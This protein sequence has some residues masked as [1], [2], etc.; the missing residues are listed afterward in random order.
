MPSL[1]LI[2]IYLLLVY[3]FFNILYRAMV[4]LEKQAKIQELNMLGDFLRQHSPFEDEEVE[5]C[6]RETPYARDLDGGDFLDAVYTWKLRK[7]QKRYL[8]PIQCEDLPTHLRPT[9]ELFSKLNED[10]L[11]E[12]VQS[13]ANYTPDAIELA[14]RIL[15]ER[16]EQNERSEEWRS[17]KG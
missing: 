14:H 13:P 15:G 7:I 17:D 11:R 9:H 5:R 12:I 6:L 16:E 2:L 10:E 3:F 1:L 4:A 8:N